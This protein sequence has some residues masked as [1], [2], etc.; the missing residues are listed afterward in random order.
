L[1]TLKYLWALLASFM[2]SLKL[3]WRKEFVEKRWG[4][5]RNIGKKKI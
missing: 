2:L 4:R 3:A 1:K 5:W